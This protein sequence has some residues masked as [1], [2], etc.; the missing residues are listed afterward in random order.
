[1]TIVAAPR[2]RHSAP[3][4]SRIFNLPLSLRAAGVDAG[5]EPKLSPSRPHPLSWAD[6]VD[7]NPGGKNVNPLSD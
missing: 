3:E 7:A 5:T 6:I 2:R 4:L 1:M